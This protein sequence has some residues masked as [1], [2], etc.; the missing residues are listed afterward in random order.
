MRIIVASTT[1]P[2]VDGGGRLIVRWTAE[3]LRAAGHEVE[4]FYLPFPPAVH[5]TLPAL[6][7]LRRMPFRSTCDRLITIRWPAHV[8]Q[9][10]NKAVWFI[11]HYRQVFDLW[12]TPYRNVEDNAE[13]RAFR[14]ILR[15]VDTQGLAEARDLFSNSLIV[16][17]RI[18]EYNGLDAEPLFPPLGGDTA[19]FRCDGYGDYVFYPSRVTP[20]KR[21]L[22]AV[23]AMAHTRTPVRLVIAGEPVNPDVRDELERAAAASGARGRIDFRFRWIPED[24]KVELLAGCLAV[25]YLPLDEDSYGYPSLEAS[26]ARKAIITLTDAGGA[27]EFV[28]DGKEGLV[29]EPTAAQLGAAFDRLYEDR[30]FAERMGEA[31]FARRAELKIDWEHVVARL[32]GATR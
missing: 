1:V 13:G 15:R 11:H 9:H 21:Q 26:H 16:R 20:I 18:H 29:V 10:D 8:L 32:V 7:G 5:A 23:E 3:A 6:V 17:D 24:E 27:L 19:R 14:E 2:H 31:S 12:D 4:E 28:R 22:L 30:D 25:P